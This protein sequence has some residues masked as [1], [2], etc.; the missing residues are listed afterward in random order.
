MM[1]INFITHY[2]HVINYSAEFNHPFILPASA[3]HHTSKK[4]RKG[5]ERRK[6]GDH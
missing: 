1:A 2:G 5:K 6:K 4:K 3:L